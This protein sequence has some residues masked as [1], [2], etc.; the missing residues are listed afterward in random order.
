MAKKRYTEVGL[1]EQYRIALENVTKN[2]TIAKEMEDLGYDTTEIDKGKALLTK[3]REKYDFNKNE[4]HETTQAYDDFENAKEILEKTYNLHR[5]KAKVIFRKDN[6]TLKQLA[7]DKALPR[8]YMKWIEAIKS[9]YTHLLA[10]TDLQTKVLK[11]KITKADLTQ[12]Q[13]EYQTLEQKRALYLREEGESQQATQDKNK[14]LDEIEEYMQDFYAV[15]KIALEDT[16]Q[17][18]ESLGLIIKS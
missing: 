4:D 10:D 12:A 13:N 15:A 17:L 14:A 16:P 9:F 3:T 11:L 7:L 8:T 6:V 18:L 1:L 5:K 2:P